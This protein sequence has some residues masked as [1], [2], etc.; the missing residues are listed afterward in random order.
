[1]MTVVRAAA[2]LAVGGV[3]VATAAGA[4]AQALSVAELVPALVSDSAVIAPGAS[5][6]HRQHFV[7]SESDLQPLYELNRVLA[8]GVGGFPFG[9]GALAASQPTA[10]GAR[11]PTAGGWSDSVLTVGR[12]Y[13][14]LALAYQATTFDTVDNLDLRSSELNLYFPHRAITGDETERDMMAQTVSLRLNR[15]VSLFALTYGWENRIDV[16]V[17]VPYVQ[18]AAD[19]RVTS[20]II[21][22]ASSN[23]PA[24]H[25]FDTISL[26]NRTLPRYCSELESGFDPDALQCH[27][28]STAR[29]FGDVVLRAKY[30]FVGGANGLAVGAD[31]RLPSGSANDFIGLGALQVRPAVMWSGSAGR[32]APRLRAEYVWSEGE[33]GSALGGGVDRSVPDEIGVAAGLDAVVHRRVSLVFDVAARRIDSLRELTASTVVFPSRGPGALPSADFIGDG[34]LQVGAERAF[35]QITG[36]VGFRASLPGSLL[37]QMSVIVPVTS[38][39]LR[40]GPSAVF[41]LTRSY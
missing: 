27:G 5:G 40:P 33:L 3:F 10:E 41:S 9:P 20:R 4:H 2:F 15:K 25:E 32:I 22:T 29:G 36:A 6:D 23:N 39:G 35:T 24:V 18:V 30:R 31:V 37:A 28:S 11:V 1:M 26:A 19:A 21:R 16:G 8:V 34:A 12:G 38:E 14:S 17:I 13:F 7:P